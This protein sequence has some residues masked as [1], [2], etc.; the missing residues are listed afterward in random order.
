VPR[1][2]GLTTGKRAAY[3][4]GQPRRESARCGMPS[5]GRYTR[6]RSTSAVNPA[7]WLAENGRSRSE[8]GQ[9]YVSAEQ[10]PSFPYPRL[11]APHAYSGRPRHPG[12]SS[13]QGPG[14]ALRLTR[15]RTV[16]PAAARL[17]HR[18][19]FAA[20]IRHGRRVG[21]TLVVMHALAPDSAPDS[22]TTAGAGGPARVGFVVS[23]A[24][25]GS[26]VR[27]RVARRLRHVMR[28]RL[29]ALPSGTRLVVRALPRSATADS[30]R[31]ATDVDRAL[32][33][34]LSAPAGR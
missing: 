5:P 27:H 8:Q 22:G 2:P 3:P 26:V 16:L 29:D 31:L 11:P 25:G 32:R 19:D 18:D 34:V 9:A 15:P 33:A 1:P 13:P 21:R 14:E 4:E 24:V 12:R 20:V 30:G 7:D 23:K 17:T 28:E 10:P 6:A